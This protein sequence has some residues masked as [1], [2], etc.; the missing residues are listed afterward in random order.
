MAPSLKDPPQGLPVPL[1]ITVTIL[2]AAWQALALGPT[3]LVAWCPCPAA[4]TFHPLH[5]NI[6]PEP[7]HTGSYHQPAASPSSGGSRQ[8]RAG[9]GR[10]GMGLVEMESQGQGTVA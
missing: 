1:L 3:A 9:Q 2:G 4:V 10:D 7:C 5:Q 6:L 8:G